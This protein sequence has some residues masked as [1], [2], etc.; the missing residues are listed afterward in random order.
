MTRGEVLK[1]ITEH[2]GIRLDTATSLHDGARREAMGA[3]SRMET[4]YDSS[5]EE[6]SAMANRLAQQVAIRRE[7]MRYLEAVAKE[8][9]S[10]RG[11]AVVVEGSQVWVRYPASGEVC[12][13]LLV[14]FGGGDEV[15]LP[16]GA[17]RLVSADAPLGLAVTAGKPGDTRRVGDMVI[18]ILRVA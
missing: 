7:L 14:P 9:D 6:L 12:R 18:Q 11:E 15:E 16:D 2:L 4:R 5:R 10:E 3:P 8:A 17:I 13:I 1:A